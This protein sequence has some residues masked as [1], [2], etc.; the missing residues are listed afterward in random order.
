MANWWWC[1]RQNIALGEILFSFDFIWFTFVNAKGCPIYYFFAFLL[2]PGHS[3]YAGGYEAQILLRWWCG[4]GGDD[5]GWEKNRIRLG[6]NE[7]MYP[8]FGST[9]VR[10]LPSIFDEWKIIR[11][12]TDFICSGNFTL[13]APF[14]CDS[15]LIDPLW[16][17]AWN[18]NSKIGLWLARSIIIWD[19]YSTTQH[20]AWLKTELEMRGELYQIE[21]K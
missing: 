4:G 8:G 20:P 21:L 17:F 11:G 7:E 16:K 9:F 12:E 6:V 1:R 13:F 10:S 15:I 2:R 5:K 19:F 14:A 3:H 18:W